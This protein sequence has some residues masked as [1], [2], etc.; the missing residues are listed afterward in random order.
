M[1]F[2]ITLQNPGTFPNIN[3]GTTTEINSFYYDIIN[4]ALYAHQII[5]NS[6]I[7]EL[8]NIMPNGTVY[9]KGVKIINTSFSNRFD[10][11]DAGNLIARSFITE[12]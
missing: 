9:L 6:G 2:N 11:T 1:P 8:M 3:F 10:L 7:T 4:D 5:E 12:L